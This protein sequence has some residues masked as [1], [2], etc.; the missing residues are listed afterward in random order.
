[1]QASPPR[2]P[3][4]S[5]I[6]TKVLV[7]LLIAAL[8]PLLA[9]ILVS[10]MQINSMNSQSISTGSDAL[11][12]NAKNALQVQAGDLSQTT[13]KQLA[14]IA[15]TT[16]E[17]ANYAGY[18]LSNPDTFGAGIYNQAKTMTRDPAKGQWYNPVTEPDSVFIPNTVPTLT[19]AFKQTLNILTYLDPVFQAHYNQDQYPTYLGTTNGI[20]R[21]Y[22][23]D[24]KTGNNADLA[25]VVPP[26][27]DVTQRPWFLAANP[28]NDPQHQPVITPPYVDAT[29]KGLLIT[30]AAPV[31]ADGTFM[32]VIGRDVTLTALLQNILPAQIGQTGYPFLVA[33]SGDII[34]MPLAGQ[35][36]FGVNL[37]AKTGEVLLNV[38]L[39]QQG[40]PSVTQLMHSI[41]NGKSG[42]V[43]LA[44]RGDYKYLAYAPVQGTPWTVV[45]VRPESE[46]LAPISALD[47][48]LNSQIAQTRLL[49][50]GLTILLIVLA[51]IVAY[52]LSRNIARPLVAI[53]Q[54]AQYLATGQSIYQDPESVE[55]Q[56]RMLQRRDEVGELARA[57][58]AIDR[59]FD[60]TSQLAD[61]IAQ[62][63]LSVR[64]HRTSDQDRLGLALENMMSYLNQILEVATRLASGDL[65]HDI[66]PRTQS[67]VLG[68]ALKYMLDELSGLVLRVQAAGREIEAAAAFVLQRSAFLVEASERQMEQI[69]HATNEASQMAESNHRVAE[70]A[71]TLARV[72]YNA[73]SQTQSGFEA[74][75]QTVSGMSQ[76][77]EE[78]K[79]ASQRVGQLSRRAQDITHVVEVISN[80]AHQ[81]NR[82][83]LDA[84][85]HASA[86]GTGGKNFGMVAGNIRHLA[87]QVKDEANQISRMVQTMVEETNLAI[88]ATKQSQQR[89][90]EGM[91]LANAA[92]GA[93]ES[94]ANVVD[95][96]S[97]LV[98]VINRIAKQQR[99]TSVA[100]AEEMQSASDITQQYSVGTRQTAQSI[101]R[102]AYLARQ[103]KESVEAFKLP[104]DSY[105]GFEQPGMYP[106]MSGQPM[107]PPVRSARPTPLL[108]QPSTVARANNGS[109]NMPNLD[110][111]LPPLPR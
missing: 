45:A 92:G 74:L 9:S 25:H 104:S 28:T 62:G 69:I 73:R 54:S 90:A 37:Q 108:P 78:V 70:D 36:D 57:F 94:I 39:D 6:A 67:D 31:Y 83:A 42:I 77:Q 15:N 41:D 33:Q 61:Q 58:E 102:L 43:R 97:Q 96:Q 98:E 79:T 59:Y 111:F 50:L 8:L 20:V 84:A 48:Q 81:T 5:S 88:A 22:V 51:A 68:N 55:Q 18:L 53:T 89:V 14:L 12:S 103:L 24:P 71:Y 2:K 29:G 27:F 13:S 35:H 44:L 106:Q 85:I 1:M 3:L 63:N 32:G 75:Q 4:L 86:A 95:Q 76:I 21:Y 30:S 64:V 16:Q 38:P 87:E 49:S 82:L 23:P 72:A 52:L 11:S 46:V 34:T 100:V 17:L 7:G 66:Q 47:N 101:E 110:D 65:S 60:E 40:D 56:Q 107:R 109:G 10:L 99:D 26:D 93:L 80:I 105:D 91:G 19:T